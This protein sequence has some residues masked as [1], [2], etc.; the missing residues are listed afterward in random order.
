ML[1]IAAALAKSRAIV[2]PEVARLISNC[3]LAPSFISDLR[4]LMVKSRIAVVLSVI[5]V[6]A[7]VLTKAIG[8]S[9]SLKV[10]VLLTVPLLVVSKSKVGGGLEAV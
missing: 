1:G 7:M 10:T 9:P 3:S 4:M 8:E 5:G 2:P 6:P